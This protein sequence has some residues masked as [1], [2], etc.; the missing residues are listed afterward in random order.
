[1]TKELFLVLIIYK[2]IEY[3]QGLKLKNG[4]NS[5]ALFFYVFW[6]KFKCKLPLAKTK[7]GNSSETFDEP[8]CSGSI[9]CGPNF[10]ANYCCSISL[11]KSPLK[12]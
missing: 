6:L 4:L 12:K 1:M 5:Y 8:F 2:L 9:F 11:F 10:R 3:A 7:C